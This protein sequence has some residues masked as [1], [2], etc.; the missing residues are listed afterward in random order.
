MFKKNK[1]LDEESMF[2]VMNVKFKHWMFTIMHELLEMQS[3]SVI[4][5][6]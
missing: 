2:D 1:N 6:N 4:F 3:S 5:Y